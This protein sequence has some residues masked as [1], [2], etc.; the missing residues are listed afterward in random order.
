MA[1]A[2]LPPA[3]VEAG[4]ALLRAADDV[5]LHPQAA[6]WVYDH[7]FDEW[8]YVLVSPLVDTIGRRRV[9]QLL[10]K[11]FRKLDLA[12]GFAVVDVS[13]ESPQSPL[14]RGLYRALPVR[15]LQDGQFI[16]ERCIINGL[17][18]DGVIYRWLDTPPLRQIRRIE[19]EF[20]RKA[21]KLARAV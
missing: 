16:F 14:F 19:K 15:G 9:Y 20:V 21:G 17:M 7:G 6:A 13:L 10:V 1:F 8:R 11:A 12:D 4:T 18:F 5:G 3:L 2:P